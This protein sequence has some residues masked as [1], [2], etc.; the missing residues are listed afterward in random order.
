M[1]NNAII[2]M[3]RNR[4]MLAP[5]GKRSNGRAVGERG[6]RAC[7]KSE[8]RMLV[9]FGV[10]RLRTLQEN[11]NLVRVVETVLDPLNPQV[12]ERSLQKFQRH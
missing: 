5:S 7:S 8:E 4:F 11:D 6:V 3:L 12:W 10:R 2:S 9:R 1:A